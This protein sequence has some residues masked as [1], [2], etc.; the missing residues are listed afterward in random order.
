MRRVYRVETPVEGG[1]V[2]SISTYTCP[3]WD[4]PE[5]SRGT[6]RFM[7]AATLTMFLSQAGLVI[8]DQ[9]GDWD[10]QPLSDTSPEIITVARKGDARTDRA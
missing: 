6:L 5:V 2:R 9:F 3:T 1:I 10:R 8:D 4:Q 7:S